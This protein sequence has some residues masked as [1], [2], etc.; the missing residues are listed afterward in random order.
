MTATYT[1][2]EVPGNCT[3]RVVSVSGQC[4]LSTTI[5]EPKEILLLSFSLVAVCAKKLNVPRLCL[6]LV[7]PRIRRS[8]T[9]P[10]PLVL[11]VQLVMTE[12]RLWT[13]LLGQY[14]CD[15]CFDP[16]DDASDFDNVQQEN[17]LRDFNCRRCQSPTMCPNCRLPANSDLGGWVCFRCAREEDMVVWTSSSSQ[18]ARWM[19]RGPLAMPMSLAEVSQG[20]WRLV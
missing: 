5:E 15:L 4:V 19:G 10:E 14:E 20:D 9:D 18:R 16:C 12:I 13:R 6:H 11:E 17:E 8:I 7:W 1:E 3:V 2:S